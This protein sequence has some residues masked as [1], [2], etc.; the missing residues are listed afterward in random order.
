MSEWLRGVQLPAEAEPQHGA[1][2]LELEGKEA[3][4]LGSLS[5]EG[6]IDKAIGKGTQALSLGRRLLSGVERKESLQ[7][8]YCI[9]PRKM[10]DYGER[11]PVPE[12]TSH[13]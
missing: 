5:R 6:G 9:S 13:A 3:K 12:G 11:Y 4:Q 8:R 2:S 7:G 1:S 10:D